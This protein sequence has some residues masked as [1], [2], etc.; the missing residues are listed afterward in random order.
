MKTE[1]ACDV[2]CHADLALVDSTLLSTKLVLVLALLKQ[3]TGSHKLRSWSESKTSADPVK[4]SK[5]DLQ[6]LVFYILIRQK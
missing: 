4:I 6:S 5:Y 2:V 1:F 3:K